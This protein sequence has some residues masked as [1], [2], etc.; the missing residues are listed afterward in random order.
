[1]MIILSILFVLILAFPI[2]NFRLTAIYSH[3]IFNTCVEEM[4]MKNYD[5]LFAVV[6]RRHFE[7]ESRQLICSR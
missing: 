3:T 4:E 6:G 5:M 7:E 2:A 1:M